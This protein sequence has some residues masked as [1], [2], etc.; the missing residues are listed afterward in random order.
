M[1]DW[2]GSGHRRPGVTLDS[3]RL[4]KAPP[5]AIEVCGFTALR[6]IDNLPIPNTLVSLARH[7]DTYLYPTTLWKLVFD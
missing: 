1:D 3:L 6:P 2:R 4:A 7:H 5:Q